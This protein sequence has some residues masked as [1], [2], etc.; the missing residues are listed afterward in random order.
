MAVGD[1]TTTVTKASQAG[2]VNEWSIYL[3]VYGWNYLQSV[4]SIT[5]NGIKLDVKELPAP[6]DSE[7][8]FQHVK[9][10]EGIV[11]I[12]FVTFHLK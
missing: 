7:Q 1:I 4:I 5:P 3:D 11:G 8:I 10:L 6:I 12:R 2:L 9:R